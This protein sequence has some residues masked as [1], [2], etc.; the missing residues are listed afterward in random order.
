MD[1]AIQRRWHQ[2][3]DH[4]EVRN[5]F[6]RTW[7]SGFHITETAEAEGEVAHRLRRGDGSPLPGW[8]SDEDLRPAWD[9]VVDWQLPG[10]NPETA[11]GLGR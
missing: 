10:G 9:S 2:A 7:C 4:V 3:G 1:G 11:S 8:F 6:E 5:R